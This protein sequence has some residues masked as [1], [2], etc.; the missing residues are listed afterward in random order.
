MPLISTDPDPYAEL[1]FRADAGELSEE[2][3]PRTQTRPGA[4]R[5]VRFPVFRA[6]RA[7]GRV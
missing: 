6:G 1:D 5:R 4:D 7:G 2:F 3:R